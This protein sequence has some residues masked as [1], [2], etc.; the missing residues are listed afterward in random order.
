VEKMILKDKHQKHVPMIKPTLGE[1]GRNELAIL[2]SSCGNIQELAGDIIHILAPIYKIAYVDADHASPQINEGEKEARRYHGSMRMTNKQQF[3]RL[4]LYHSL[5]VHDKRALFIKEDMILVNGNHFNAKSQVLIIDPQKSMESKVDKLTDLQAIVL[6]QSNGKIPEYIKNVV[7]QWERIPIFN[8]EEKDSFM[9]WMKNWLE[10]QVCP[11]N[12]LILTGGESKRMKKDKGGLTYHGTTQREHLLSMAKLYCTQSYISCN[13]QQ[14]N[15][16]KDDFPVIEDTFLNL[17]P[18][19]GILSALRFNPN[20]A[21]LA[22]ACDLPL[23]S[24]KTL[25]YLIAHRNPQKVATAFLDPK[26]E[27][28]E[29]LITIWEPKSYLILL[30]FLSQG[31]SCPRKVLINS[32]VEILESP[33]RKELMNVNYPEEYETVQKALK[34]QE[35]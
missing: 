2:G 14:A 5:S 24:D 35:S 29:P 10:K 32:D 6:R 33:D 1:F 15:V 4:D 31:I 21:W 16:L 34:D 7:P 19:G 8:L 26:G 20:A 13:A 3:F 12:G 30:N 23:L 28:P 9:L 18:M 25:G 17:G 22:L 11:L 27:F